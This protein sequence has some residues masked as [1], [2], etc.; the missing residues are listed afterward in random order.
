MVSHDRDFLQGLTQKVFEFRD[1]NVKQYIGDIYDFLA[2]RKIQTLD[3][4]SAQ[5]IKNQSSQQEQSASQNKLQYGKRKLFE[6]EIRKINSKIEKTEV[7]I[8]KVE[9]E[10][11]Q[12]DQMLA[13]PEQ[14][15]KA[16][17]D[18]SLYERYNELKRTMEGLMETWEKLHEEVENMKPD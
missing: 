8:Q 12:I 1:G 17:S 5:N 10:I 3:Q 6:K 11:A 18:G 15:S 16:I 4:L 13:N 2:K 7:Q 9:A 14:N